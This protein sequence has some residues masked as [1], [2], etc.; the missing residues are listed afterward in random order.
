M[1]EIES[2]DKGGM[3]LGTV[4]GTDLFEKLF[5]ALNKGSERVV[6]RVAR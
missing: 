4:A 2:N 1:E 5:K 3:D 6:M